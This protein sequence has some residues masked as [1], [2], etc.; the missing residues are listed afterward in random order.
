M[1]KKIASLKGQIDCPNCF[2]LLEWDSIDD[3]KWV[4]GNRYIT[5]PI[6]KQNLI[7]KDN[8]DYWITSEDG[9]EDGS[10][11]V[12]GTAVVGQDTAG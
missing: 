11:A 10:Q 9:S 4:A 7:L 1:V 8:I 12:V 2:S 6:C 3:I 5:C